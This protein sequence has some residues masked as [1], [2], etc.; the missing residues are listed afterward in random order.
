MAKR[1]NKKVALIGSLVFA[2]LVVIVILAI[3]HFSRDPEQFIRD[4][5]A[6]VKAAKEAIDEQMKAEKYKEAERCYREASGLAKTDLLR[7]NILFKLVD[8]YLETDKWS[9][10]LGCWEEII[11]IDPKDTKAR[12][13][14]LKYFYILADSGMR[15]VWNEVGSQASEFIEMAEDAN[16]LMEDTS[17]L[18]SFTIHKKGAGG[19]RLGPYL[20][21]L[22][23]R[24]TLEQTKRGAF[25]N[26][27]ESLDKAVDDLK[28]VQELE[29]GNVNSYL[30]LAQAA[31]E[32]GELL[33]SRGKPEEKEKQAEQRKNISRR[34]LSV[35]APMPEPILI[36]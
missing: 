25:T 18:E 13:G 32:R 24:A 8:V 10:V 28:K 5:D 3:L 6:A 29:P 11:K 33:A 30:Y 27:D 15:G 16:L 34:L 22:K 12:Y 20:Y 26:P 21:L 36:Y 2:L 7:A 17:R 14:R 31:I 1:L 35:Q 23:G 19:Q 4:G 9:Y